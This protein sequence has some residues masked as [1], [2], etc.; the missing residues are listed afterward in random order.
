MTFDINQLNNLEYDDA[1][2]LL[3]DYIND[4]IE[5]FAQSPEGKAYAQE[6]PEFGGWI[7]SFIEMS[8]NYEGFTLPKMTKADAQ[9][10]MEYLLPRKLTL[11]DRSEAEDAIPE[12]VAF[13]NFLKRE[14][15]FRSA[16][17]I[18]KYLSSIKDKFTDW[19]FDPARGGI[20]KNFFMIGIQ[21][22]FDMT[23]REGL[24]A[25]QKEYNQKLISPNFNSSLFQQIEI[26]PDNS[27]AVQPPSSSRKSSQKKL[28]TKP[29]TK[30]FDS[31]KKGKK[32]QDKK[33]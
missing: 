19:M 18:A 17:A 30:G 26:I 24:N 7:N 23:T 9:V 21:A 8:Y 20:A 11:L 22:G 2:P 27:P 14:Y 3:E 31:P 6:Y 4:V 12:L 28:Q 25:F 16:G 29:K 5:E 32:S 33:R 15:K 1:E 13:W 10:V